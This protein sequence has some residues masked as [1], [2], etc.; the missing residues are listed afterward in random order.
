MGKSKG[1]RIII[2]LECLCR[3]SSNQLVRKNKVFC[4]TTTKNRRNTPSKLKLRKHCPQCNCHS[5]FQ[6][7]K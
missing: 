1:S 5:L 3:H 7:I 6:E 2:T 4:Y